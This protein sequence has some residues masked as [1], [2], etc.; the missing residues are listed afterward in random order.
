MIVAIGVNRNGSIVSIQTVE[1]RRQFAFCERSHEADPSPRSITRS[2]GRCEAL[3][4]TE[5]AIYAKYPRI[6]LFYPKC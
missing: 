6:R 3:N 4:R 5:A 1:G 2:E